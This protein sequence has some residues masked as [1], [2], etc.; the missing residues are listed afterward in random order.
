ME[1]MPD[2]VQWFLVSFA[3]FIGLCVVS[4]VLFKAISYIVEDKGTYPSP[5]EVRQNIQ[6]NE[7][8]ERIKRAQDIAQQQKREE[9]LFEKLEKAVFFSQK[10]G[11]PDASQALKELEALKTKKVP[12]Y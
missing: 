6:Q 7:K 3:V 11:G 4:I 10:N 2:F 5:K 9:E 1:Q 8:E 12:R